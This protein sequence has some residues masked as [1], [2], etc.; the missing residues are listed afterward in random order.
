MIPGGY[1][2]LRRRW[3]VCF[4][5]LAQGNIEYKTKTINNTTEPIWNEV[6]FSSSMI[7]E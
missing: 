2:T 3:V 1:F 6:C 7:G 5:P 4:S